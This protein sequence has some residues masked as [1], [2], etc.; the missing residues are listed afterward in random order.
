MMTVEQVA[1]CGMVPV[2]VLEDAAQA[3]PTAPRQRPRSFHGA[4]PVRRADGALLHGPRHALRQSGA[5]GE[6]RQQHPPLAEKKKNWID[7]DAGRLLSGMTL[8]ALGQALMDHVLAV[9]SGQPTRNEANGFRDLAI[10]KQ[11]VTL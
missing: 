4:G 8:D 5:H 2:V 7:F 6:D 10:F 3:V 9:T 1:A 11:G